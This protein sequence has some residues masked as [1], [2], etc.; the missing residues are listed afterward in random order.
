M[1]HIG[2][3]WK[4][5]NFHYHVKD[6]RQ[7]MST[8]SKTSIKGRLVNNGSLECHQRGSGC[9]GNDRPEPWGG[10]GCHP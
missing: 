4:S 2:T 7:S 1:S 3:L 8:N 5:S 6:S 10:M 9:E